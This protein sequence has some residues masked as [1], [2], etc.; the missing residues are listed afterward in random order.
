VQKG[1]DSVEAG[2]A[3]PSRE[4]VAHRPCNLPGLAAERC[5]AVYKKDRIRPRVTEEIFSFH[6]DALA[7]FRYAIEEFMKPKAKVSIF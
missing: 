7:A 4:E 1:P 2:F 5:G 6:D 3:L